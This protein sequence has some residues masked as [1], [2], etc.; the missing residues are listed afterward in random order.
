MVTMTCLRRHLPCCTLNV[1]DWGI[2]FAECEIRG[3]PFDDVVAAPLGIVFEDGRW[4][5][6]VIVTVEGGHGVHAIAAAGWASLDFV[7]E[8]VI[9]YSLSVRCVTDGVCV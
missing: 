2:R 4:F 8:C 3:T 9:A 5:F 7:G 6:D 1:C